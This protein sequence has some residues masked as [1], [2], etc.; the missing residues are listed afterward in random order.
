[1]TSG[2]T[3]TNQDTQKKKKDW[4]MHNILEANFNRLPFSGDIDSRP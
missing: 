1:M 4:H 3:A 2:K